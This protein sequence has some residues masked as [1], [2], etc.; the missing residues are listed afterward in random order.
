VIPAPPTFRI[1]DGHARSSEP[2]ARPSPTGA[3]QRAIRVAFCGPIGAPGKPAGGGYEAANRR[4]CDA[5]ARHGVAVVELPYPKVTASA[6]RRLWRYAASFAKAAA[7][8]L[9]HRADYDLLHLTPLNMHF[10]LPETLLLSCARRAGKPVLLDV[11]AGTFTRHYRNGGTFYRRTID[12]SL[13]LASRVSVEGLEYMPFVRERSHAT[14]FYFPNYVDSPALRNL[15]AARADSGEQLVR[16]VYFGRIVA[17]KGVETTLAALALLRAQGHQVALEFIGDGPADYIAA[18]AQRHASLP[19]TWTA[20]LPVHETMQRA[21]QA[22][23][24]VFPSRHAGEGHSNAL[25]EAMSV[26][27]VPVCSEQGFTRS[28]VGEA[29]VVLPVDAT[30]ADYAQAIGR[31]LAEGRWARLSESARTRVRAL[32]SEEAALPALVSHYR[33]MLHQLP[34]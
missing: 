29:G 32:Y 9:R 22:H 10:A 14:V 25:N 7:F 17:E 15:P 3:P 34:A 23:F 2:T 8:L 1:S 27:L 21:A 13:R 16:L 5:L 31:I 12:R 20:G 26:G 11:R 19:V 30:A 6:V 4:N 18:L 33:Q 24:F 28:V